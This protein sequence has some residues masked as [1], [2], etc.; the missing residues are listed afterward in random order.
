PL[1]QQ[2]EK[3]KKY[4]LLREELQ[5]V[6]VAVWLDKLEKL[7]A[8]AKK[9]EEDYNSAAFVLEQAQEELNNLYT[10]TETM[11][12]DLRQESEQVENLRVQVSMLEGARQQLEGQCA[13]IR[14]SI[15]H[16]EENIRRNRED[17]QGQESRSSGIAAQLDQTRER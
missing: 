4:L 9:A 1:K 12:G 13:V 2:S 6:E 11:G 5:G 10:Q 7:S 17:L 14:E 8:E 3:A 15:R 16:N